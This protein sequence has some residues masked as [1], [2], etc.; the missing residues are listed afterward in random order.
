[1]QDAVNLELS[2]LK[3]ALNIKCSQTI[4]ATFC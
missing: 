2:G 3:I 4:L 1:M